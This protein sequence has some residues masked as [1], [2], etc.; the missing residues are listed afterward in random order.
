MAWTET[1]RR[2]YRREGLRYASDLTDAEWALIAPLMPSALVIG[3]PRTTSFRRVVEAILYMASG[4]PGAVQCRFISF[5]MKVRA[6]A[7]SLVLLAK[8]SGASPSWS[9]ARQR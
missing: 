2:Q 9:T 8:D 3:R 7:L 6:A 5:F 1:T 4:K